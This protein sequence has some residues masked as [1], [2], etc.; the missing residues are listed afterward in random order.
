[1]FQDRQYQVDAAIVRIM[2]MRKTLTHNQLIAE[3]YNQ[4][5]FPVQVELTVCSGCIVLTVRVL[6]ERYG[7]PAVSPF[8]RLVAG[9]RTVLPSSVG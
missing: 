1:M 2:K 8:G 6:L 4:L 9:V 7:M 5:K 3:L